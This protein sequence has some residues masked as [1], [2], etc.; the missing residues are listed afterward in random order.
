[1]NLSKKS[2]YALRATINLG[3]A[4]EVGRGTVSGAEL[5]EANRLPLKFV[6]R[7]LQELRDA[8]IVET[9]R[10]KFGGYALA[11]PA[12]QIGV[13][14]LVR[15]MDGR[16]APLCCASENAYQPCTCPDE[17]HCGLRMVMIDVRNAIAN[18]LDR[19]S[20]AQVVE[21]TLRK[22]RRDGIVPPFAPAN[23]SSE[24][25]DS[26][27]R[28]ADPADGFLAGLSQLATSNPNQDDIDKL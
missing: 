18:I 17:D 23:N 21:V 25:P 28:R 4:A 24:K 13:G 9:M 12:D 27:K 1:M 22:M 19:Y 10:G 5:A 3:I 6:E 14:E 26:P 8:G 7:I 20:I 11:K 16:L 2:E 15:L